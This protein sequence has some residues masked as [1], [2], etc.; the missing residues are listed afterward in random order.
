[1]SSVGRRLALDDV[2]RALVAALGRDGRAPN[3][4]LARTLG[5]S[6]N[7]ARSRIARLVRDHG[8]RVTA[9]PPGT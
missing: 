9:G 4:E 1:M 8:L 2:D 3:V 6:E 5:V 7:T